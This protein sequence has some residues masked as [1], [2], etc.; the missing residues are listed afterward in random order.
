MPATFTK[1]GE[2]LSNTDST[3]I[4]VT[5]SRDIAADKPCVAFYVAHATA[6]PD[7]CTASGGGV[8]WTKRASDQRGN[9]RITLFT[10]DGVASPSG[11]TIT[12]DN[13]QGAG[14][15]NDAWVYEISSGDPAD[16]QYAA[17]NLNAASAVT[18]TLAST[19]D[20]D[21]LGMASAAWIENDGTISWTAGFTEDDNGTHTA[22]TCDTSVAADSGSPPISVTA[23]YSGTA[24]NTVIVYV[25]IEPGTAPPTPPA[26]TGDTDDFMRSQSNG[27]G[28]SSGAGTYDLSG[29]S[30]Q[31]SVVNGIGYISKTVSG[32]AVAGLYPGQQEGGFS[33]ANGPDGGIDILDVD[34]LFAFR[35]PLLSSDTTDD[36][37]IVTRL[38]CQE[39]I[40]QTGA[41][42]NPT[43][44]LY[45]ITLRFINPSDIIEY[46]I[47]SLV[48]NIYNELALATMSET[49]VANEW[50]W[51]RSQAVGTSP[52][53]IRF[54]IWADGDTEPSTWAGST[55]D[56]E[57][58]LQNSGGWGV[59]F[60]ASPGE[61]G[62]LHVAGL[63]ITEAA[64][65]SDTN[66]MLLLAL[67]SE[68]AGTPTTV[69]DD[70]TADA[71]ILKTA[72]ATFTADSVLFKTI[73]GTFTADAVLFKTQTGTFTADAL[74]LKV[75]AATFTADSVLFKTTS[76]T[77]TSDSYLLAVR[78]ATFTA[79]SVLFKTASA[80]FTA[81]S[82]LFKTSAATFTT[83]AYLLAVRTATFTA[84]AYLLAVREVTFTADSVLF[85]TSSGSFTADAV[86]FKTT[87]VT[88]T[89]DAVLALTTSAT[90]TADAYLL[91]IRTATFTADSVIFKTQAATFTADS[92]LVATVAATFTA[93]AVIL[94][95]D[96]S[97]TFTADAYLLAVRSATFTADAVIKA[98]ID[99]SFIADA[100][101]FK[102]ISATF[103]ADSVI[104]KEAIATFTADAVLF[105]TASGSFTADAMI[106][107]IVAGSFTADA[108][109]KATIAGTFTADSV[110]FKTS[111]AT[112][113]ADAYM[114]LTV[115]QSFSADAVI[116]KTWESSTTADAYLL[117]VR[118]YTFVADA[119][120]TTTISED[121]TADSVLSSTFSEDFTAD[122]VIFK[123][124]SA[125]FTADAY[126]LTAEEGAFSA[127]AVLLKVQSLS[128]VADA[129][130]I[131]VGIPVWTTPLDTVT[132]P[133]T[134]TLA[135]T[136]PS[137]VGNTHFQIQLDKVNT[138]DG[139]DFRSYKSHYDQTGW[140]YW[141][142][143]SWE[144]IPASGVPNSFSGNEARFTL[145]TA[146]DAGLWYRRVRA[147]V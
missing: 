90:F 77:F 98:A 37:E 140:E 47:G 94:K 48:G 88:F 80:T 125:T 68:G 40:P 13:G 76:A 31:F 109:L 79:D 18:A 102:V 112:F 127:D 114:I 143:D 7:T 124:Q 135:F 2:N 85:K 115:S 111:S 26:G 96:I 55:T 29:T 113:S 57:T 104:K 4:A 45:A 146:L 81:D 118:E 93:D 136:I 142:G 36:L 101:L 116:Q 1:L 56:S 52:T 41:G 32:T 43:D 139:G 51:F 30:S 23:S 9:I 92:V 65:E 3:S 130:L 129:V 69:S 144:P 147:G 38:R 128:F 24:A 22:P 103:T 108:N 133:D 82:V 44:D 64:P 12:F 34:S 6:P 53:T 110:L 14:I 50:W 122:A 27:W 138:F 107:Q 59:R 39:D 60:Y 33:P 105:K 141:D 137:A 97:A 63:T 19:P 49:V 89:A 28:A 75:Q 42:P 70:F 119:V 11:T 71:V 21:A 10:S 121:F 145:P 99:G 35:L 8:T 58:D 74:L 61:G 100:V 25:S 83:D 66:Y 73:S 67:T 86:L 123:E 91:A 131:R 132:I 84:D 62:E 78:T 54:R 95:T 20:S 72:S 87:A 120:L 126:I 106:N 134:P 15:G 16:W 46:E 117:A 5:L 17:N